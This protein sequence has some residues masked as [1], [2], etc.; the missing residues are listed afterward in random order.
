MKAS[1]DEPDYLDELVKRFVKDRRVC[2]QAGGHEGAWP[3]H[4]SRLFDTVI[5]LEPEWRSFRRLVIDVPENVFPVRAALWSEPKRSGFWVSKGNRKKSHLKDGTEVPTV[6]IDGISPGEVD[7]ICL[8]IEGAEI[9][10]LMGAQRT[11]ETRPVVAVE[12][13]NQGRFD[14]EASE[15]AVMSVLPG[16]RPVEKYGL[17][18]VFAP[19]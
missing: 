17:D 1:L 13:K 12:I 11:L 19:E 18:T 15:G 10:A 5:T 14:R 16:Y 2:I 6:T 3:I 9:N 8:D 4:L 7:F